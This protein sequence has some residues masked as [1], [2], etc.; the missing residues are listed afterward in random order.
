MR[1]SVLIALVLAVC[2]GS[3]INY[4]TM[5]RK[6]MPFPAKSVPMRN[7]FAEEAMSR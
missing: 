4:S 5:F 3:N 7:P 1:S 2:L 6:A